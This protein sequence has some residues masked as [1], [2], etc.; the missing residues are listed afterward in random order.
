MENIKNTDN[1]T[2]KT[3]SERVSDRLSV[4]SPLSPTN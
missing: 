2:I 4:D 1:L 3:F